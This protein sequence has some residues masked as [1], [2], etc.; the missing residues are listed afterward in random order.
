MNPGSGYVPVPFEDIFSSDV[1]DGAITFDAQFDPEDSN[2]AHSTKNNDENT[3]AFGEV[4]IDSPNT[5]SVSS[6]ALVSDW[7]LTSCDSKS[8]QPQTV[9]MRHQFPHF[10]FA[11]SLNYAHFCQVL[12]YCSKSMDNSGCGHVFIGSAEHTI[13]QMPSSCGL[14]PYARVASLTPHTNQSILSTSHQ[15]QKPANEFV[16]SLS[17]DYGT[18]PRLIHAMKRIY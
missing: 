18:C 2:T 17:F 4:F 9:S 8:D 7:V 10:P 6:M 1:V 14:G 12:A 15:A 3:E 11:L 5:Q 16:Y 13:V